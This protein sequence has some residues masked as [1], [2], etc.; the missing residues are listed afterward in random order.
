M[1][2]EGEKKWGRRP[3]EHASMDFFGN[4]I[5]LRK[6]LISQWVCRERECYFFY[7]KSNIYRE[8]FLKFCIKNKVQSA[9]CNFCCQSS[10]DFSEKKET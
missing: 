9:K 8:K 2:D 10:L 1:W 4:G 7:S 3:N 5:N 6:K